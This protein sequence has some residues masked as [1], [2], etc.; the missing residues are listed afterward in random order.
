MRRPCELLRDKLIGIVDSLQG[1]LY[2][3][4]DARGEFWNPDK[5]WNGGDVCEAL[6]GVFERHGL[7]PGSS[8]PVAKARQRYLLY[9]FDAD[10]LMSRRLYDDPH[11]AADD[12]HQFSDVIVVALSLD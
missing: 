3:D 10:E 5:S 11:E 8:I 1:I 9:N 4:L 2:L 7:V 6:A 12:A